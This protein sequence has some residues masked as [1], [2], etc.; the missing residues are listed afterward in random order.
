MPTRTTTG[1]RPT[2]RK[3]TARKP[4][5]TKTTTPT[6]S[7]YIVL[8]DHSSRNPTYWEGKFHKTI[9]A[10]KAQF[11]TI[12]DPQDYDPEGWADDI[13][14]IFAVWSDGVIQCCD[15]RTAGF[16]VTPPKR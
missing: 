5:E 6:I 2:A 1:R 3:S 16:T 10:A 9:E 14:A 15:I 4:D 11:E 12:I 13:P 7:G 8:S